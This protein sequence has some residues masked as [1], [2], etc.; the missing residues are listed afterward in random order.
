VADEDVLKGLSVAPVEVWLNF[1]TMAGSWEPRVVTV[2]P[3]G[4]GVGRL[5]RQTFHLV[6]ILVQLRLIYLSGY[7]LLNLDI[8]LKVEDSALA[9][10]YSSILPLISLSNRQFNIMFSAL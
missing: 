3:C 4:N 6:S 10:V 7:S 5:G 9:N 8:I 2:L 1:A